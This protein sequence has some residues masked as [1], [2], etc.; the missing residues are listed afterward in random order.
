ML[1]CRDNY[2]EKYTETLRMDVNSFDGVLRYVKDHITKQNAQMRKAISPQH[3][4]C[5]TLFYLASMDSFKT[6]AILFRLGQSIVRSIVFETC[7]AIWNAMSGEFLTV[8]SC[9]DEWIAVAADCDRLWNY[10]NCIGAIDGKNCSIQCPPNTGSEYFNYKKFFSVVLLGVCDANYKFIYV[11]VGTAGRWSDGG[12]FDT[13]SLNQ[14][15]TIDSLNIPAPR[16][17]LG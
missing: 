7:Q 14:A 10:P 13:C 15:M 4:L 12:T 5:V 2:Q 17:L 3:R 6:L 1:K 11:D 16:N 9:Q 8:P